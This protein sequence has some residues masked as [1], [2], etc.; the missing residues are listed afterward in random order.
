MLKQSPLFFIYRKN[1]VRAIFRFLA[2]RGT[3]FFNIDLSL[4]YLF[5]SLFATSVRS[6]ITK[7]P[8]STESMLLRRRVLKPDVWFLF[9]LSFF[10]F[11]PVRQLFFFFYGRCSLLYPFLSTLFLMA[12][13]VRVFYIPKLSYGRSA[14]KTRRRIK[15]KIRK[16]IFAPTRR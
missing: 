5:R 13:L 6:I 10:K 9:F 4:V 7:S 11:F 15:K 8:Y 12:R 1:K 3:L 16:K 2:T 14:L